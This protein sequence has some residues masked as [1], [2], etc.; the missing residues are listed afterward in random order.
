LRISSFLVFFQICLF[1]F[2]QTSIGSKLESSSVFDLFQEE[3]YEKVIM[4]LNRKRDLSR[5]EEFILSLSQLKTRQG[6]TITLEDIVKRNPDHSLTPLARFYLG[7]YFFYNG[8]SIKSRYYVNKTKSQGLSKKD[9]SKYSLIIGVQSLETGNYKK[10]KSFFSQAQKLEFEDKKKLVYY[11]AFTDY[12]LGNQNEA[13]NGFLLSSDGGEYAVSSQFFIAKINLDLG[14]YEEVIA[15]AQFELSDEK[16]V[17]N[18]GFYQLIGE[19]YAKKNS[20]AKAD[21]YFDKAIQLHPNKPSPALYYQAGV[22]KFKIGNDA[23]AIKYLT[24]AGIGAGEYAQLSA[25]QLGR[26]YLQRKELDNALVAYTEASS[27]N[28]AS[29][30]EESLYQVSKLHA[31]LA[32]YS[33]SLNYCNDYLK[34]FKEGKWALEIQELIAET[35][36]RTSNY[37]LA[38]EHLESLGVSGIAQQSVYQKVTFQKAQL[39]F[40]DAKF[41]QS[42]AWFNK[43]NKYPV[44][45]KLINESLFHIGEAFMAQEQFQ[46][47]IQSYAKQSNPTALTYYGLGYAYYNL[48]D[49][50]RAIEPF[51]RF[52]RIA[53]G[54]LKIDGQVRIADCYYASKRYP[55]ALA[56]YTS[57][58]KQ[59]QSS[60]LRFQIG[61]VQK[62]LGNYEA[63]ISS[64]KKVDNKSSWN[65]DAIFNIASLLFEKA[66]FEE[67]EKRYSLLISNSP[68][69]QL[70]SKSLLNRAISY[71]N[72][73]LLQESKKDYE[74]ILDDHLSSKEAFSAILGL[75][76]LKQKGISVNGLDNKIANYKAANPNDNSLEAVEFESAKAQYFDLDYAGSIKALKAFIKE[77]PKSVYLPEAKYYMADAFYRGNQFEEALQVFNTLKTYRNNLTGRVLSRLGEINHQL[78]KYDEAIEAYQQLLVL[79]LS[80]KDSYNAR[81]GSMK[82]Y[83]DQLDYPNAIRMADEILN[84]EWK[85]LNAESMAILFK[86]RSL[87]GLNNESLASLEFK[88][89]AKGSDVIA[90]E[91]NYQLAM[92]DF[93]K[94]DYNASLERLFALNAAFGSYAEWID[95]SYLLISDIYLETDQLFQ[96]K[97]TLRS[98]VEHSKNQKVI[99]L[100]HEKLISIEQKDKSVTDSTKVNNN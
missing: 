97:A 61:L 28:D 58:E 57:L 98:I 22:S 87:M 84:E 70:L 88:K 6:N 40:N 2:A 37:D 31:Q 79:A 67:A 34:N 5:D 30:K 7:E 71:S 8:D 36:L 44:D 62:E 69:S 65:D 39:L 86:A 93:R 54:D 43:S 29:I 72:L 38:I 63:A 18:S 50:T 89:I 14:K 91:A 21:A 3:Q 23:K 77:Y 11:Q 19:A 94:K 99:Q 74:R 75:Q 96:A 1:G 68:K 83:S 45:S 15:L 32:D 76:E 92:I 60:Y 4:D 49:Y 9:Q 17:T 10:A 27:S 47:A 51:E 59:S 24:E 48:E 52:I 82:V 16:T 33:Q 73:N 80:P 13:L 81:L 53:A 41:D 95:R 12:H 55:E 42:I 78:F 90:A 20:V 100:A 26:L 25:F 64:L 66:N 56:I 35:Y 85:P 46:R